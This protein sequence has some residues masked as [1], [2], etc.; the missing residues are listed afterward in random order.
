MVNLVRQS[1]VW[2][3]LLGG[4]HVCSMGA[5]TTLYSALPISQSFRTGKLREVWTLV[6]G[7][8][9]YVRGE[10]GTEV[11]PDHLVTERLGEA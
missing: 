10:G 2:P 3:C 7:G 4:N 1:S 5:I 6:E 9:V 8:T 11:H